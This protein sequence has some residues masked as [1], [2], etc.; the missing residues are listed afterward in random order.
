MNIPNVTKATMLSPKESIPFF[1]TKPRVLAVIRWMKFG[2]QNRID[3]DGPRIRLKCIREG[4]RYMT[5]I[6]WIEKFQQDCLNNSLELSC[7]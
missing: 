6:E 3:K 7:R 1:A 2:I 5:T 4:H